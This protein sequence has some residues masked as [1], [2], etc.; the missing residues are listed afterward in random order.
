MLRIAAILTTCVAAVVALTLPPYVL[1]CS[2]SDPNLNACA[3]KHGRDAIPRLVKGDNKYRIPVL[4]PLTIPRIKVEGGA[5][6]VGSSLTFTDMKFNGLSQADLQDVRIDMEKMRIDW[7]MQVPRIVILCQYAV[8]GRVLILPIIGSGPA[9][10]TLTNVSLVYSYDYKLEN[11]TDGETYFEL[12]DSRL[13]F[14]TQ[15]AYIRLDNL[16]N[17]DR[18]LG[19][20]M[21]RFLDDHWQD[22]VKEVGPYIA[23]GIGQAIKQIISNIAKLVPYKYIFTE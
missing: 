22:I 19:N 14:D 20:S 2:K 7:V 10:I 3:R 17:G 5:R 13:K 11:R 15:R 16:F 23:D 12:T 4:E 21:N 6:H 18:F 9:N 8:K 1:P